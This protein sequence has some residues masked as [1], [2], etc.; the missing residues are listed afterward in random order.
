MGA[1]FAICIESDSATDHTHQENCP[2]KYKVVGY[3]GATIRQDEALDSKFITKLPEG[4]IIV[5]SEIK[6]RRCKVE[7]PVQGW[8]SIRTESDNPPLYIL[9]LVHD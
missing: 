9:E 1:L 4:T 7:K 6:G 8:A 3:N 2:L 5:A